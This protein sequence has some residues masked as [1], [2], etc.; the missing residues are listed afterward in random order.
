[1]NYAF[2]LTHTPA[3]PLSIISAFT[4]EA[5]DSTLREIERVVASGE[6]TQ[7]EFKLSTGQRSDA[8]R[9][10]CGMLNGNGGFVLFGVTDDGRVV[11]QQVSTGTLEDVVRE[12]QRIS[13]QPL[14]AP[15]TVPVDGGRAVILI[16]VPRGEGPYTYDGRPYMR[17]G[18]T[19][20][21]MPP[22]H[23]Q[24]LLVERMQSSQRWETQV[25]CGVTF[26]DLDPEEVMRTAD[27]AVRRNRLTDPLT[28][29]LEDLLL[30]FGLL[31]DGEL[32][33]GALVLF[34]RRDR[35]L[36]MFP[37]CALRMARFRGREMGDFLDTRQETGNA[38]HL[39]AKAQEFLRDHLP[40][41]GRIVPGLFERVDD[42]LYPP[43]ALREALANAFCH[44]DYAVHG[45]SVGL[46]LFDD[47]LEISST[48]P[49]RFGLR[50]SD[51][52][53]PHPSLP[54]NPTI[55]SVLY[56][57]GII[58]KWGRGTIKIDELTQRAGLARPEFH[59]R[60]GE[61]VVR[62]FARGYVPPTRVSH[63]LTE[64]QREL[65]ALISELGPTSSN[66]LQAKLST[67]VSYPHLLRQLAHLQLVGLVEK[68]G[69]ARATRW[70]LV[71][72]KAPV[73]V[74]EFR[75]STTGSTS[76]SPAA[77]D[78]LNDSRD[79]KEERIGEDRRG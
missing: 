13:P 72:Q 77:A 29:R 22:E 20:V 2:A 32:L 75:P 41:A 65:L 25:A 36:P 47:R 67:S 74:V 11:G 64:L 57:R 56:L 49:L 5:A 1:M 23:Y 58:E 9:A 40:V 6:S 66:A 60:A 34:G 15:E 3:D 70:R 28:R 14:L 21:Q 7:V 19:T 52:L 46:A 73:P 12:L 31:R 54:W 18:P 51:L 62:F 76:S 50:P 71:G 39:F 48:G 45:G 43:V 42:P 37:Q 68:T 24:R 44:R 27:E 8:A 16:R 63:E 53:A 30:G 59:E 61:V 17:V 55:A 26:E 10:A 4:D 35:L 38:F 78:E 33:N 79:G 69:A